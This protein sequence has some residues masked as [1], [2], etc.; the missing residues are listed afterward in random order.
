MPFPAI[1]AAILPLV[2]D[3]APAITRFLFGERAEEATTKV[4]NTVQKITGKDVR[5]P[6]GVKEAR[7]L[8]QKDPELVL[9]MQ[10][11]LA[12]LD[13]ELEKAYLKDVQDAWERD[14]ELKR[15]GHHDIRGNILLISAYVAVIAICVFLIWGSIHAEAAV[16]GTVGGFLIGMG[17][18]FARNIGSAFDFEFGSSRGSKDKDSKIEQQLTLMRNAA[19]EGLEF[20]QNIVE[21]A[22]WLS[23]RSNQPLPPRWP[24]PERRFASASEK[25]DAVW[26]LL[27]PAPAAGPSR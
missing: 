9:R 26:R 13:A 5:T 17:G 23:G 19:K 22:R 15:L 18:M 16:N 7:E 11:E 24:P 25:P 20:K 27:R 21:R 8:L 14:L 4:V 3:Y 1:A 10:T 6:E 12:S 2:A